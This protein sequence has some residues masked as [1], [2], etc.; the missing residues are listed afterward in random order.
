MPTPMIKSFA[1]KTGKTVGEVEKLWNE[2]KAI[3]FK[4]GKEDNYAYIVGILKKKLGLNES[5]ENVSFKD[6]LKDD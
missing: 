1:D 4:E 6:F 3:A 5:V 2:A